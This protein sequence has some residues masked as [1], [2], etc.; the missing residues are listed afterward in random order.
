MSYFAKV[1]NG[2]VTE[3]QIASQEFMDGYVDTS[4]GTWIETWEEPKGAS[5]RYHYASIGGNYDKEGDFFYDVQ[6]FPSW[7]LNRTTG[8]WEPPKELPSDG[9]EYQWNEETKSWDELTDYL[10]GEE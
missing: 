1:V 9:K 10:V 5:E 7:I 6:P 8:V 2:K 4:P 3:I